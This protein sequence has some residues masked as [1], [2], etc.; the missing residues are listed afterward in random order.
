MLMH[1]HQSCGGN[2]RIW[3]PIEGIGLAPHPWCV[4]CG[5]VKNISPDKAKRLGYWVNIMAEIADNFKITK[6]QQRLAIKELQ[7]YDGFEDTYAMTFSA[8]RKIFIQILKKYFN[9]GE[10]TINSFIR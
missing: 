6:V 8:Q 10:T 5:V 4:K 9:L 1:I 7:S 3:L 2:E